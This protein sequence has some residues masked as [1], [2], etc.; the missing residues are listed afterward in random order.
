MKH[1]QIWEGQMA[2]IARG[3]ST[4]TVA[5]LLLALGG[6]G[7]CGSAAG[8]DGREPS[9]SPGAVRPPSGP[10]PTEVA[11]ITA[12]DRKVTFYSATL[13]SGETSIGIS[14]SGSA[15]DDR[16]LVNLLLGQKLTSQEIYLALAPEGA[17]APP[18]LVA[19]QDQDAAAMGRSA[20]VQHATVPS[21]FVQKTWTATQCANTVFTAGLNAINGG[22]TSS[23]NVYTYTNTNLGYVTVPNNETQC[24]YTTNYAIMGT[25]NAGSVGYSYS[26]DELYGN[27]CGSEYVIN[28]G[29]DVYPGQ[30]YYY[31][32][33]NTGGAVYSEEANTF[34]GSADTFYLVGGLM[35]H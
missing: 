23:G 5:A 20:E 7:G 9:P 16:A 29:T 14:E 1:V 8:G 12:Y 24:V 10:G 2:S 30:W 27:K 26:I 13:A 4:A 6:L 19:A 3:C 22:Q 33:R 11:S 28:S 25:C 31:Y 21:E 18:A 35:L 34:G 17:T 15:Y 32:W